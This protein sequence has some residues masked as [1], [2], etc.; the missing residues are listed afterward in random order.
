MKNGADSLKKVSLNS[1][2]KAFEDANPDKAIPV[3]IQAAFMNSGQVCLA[4]SRI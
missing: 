2:E 3:S 1:A 4:G